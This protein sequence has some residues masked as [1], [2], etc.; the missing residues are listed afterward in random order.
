MNNDECESTKSDD[1]KKLK[2][3]EDREKNNKLPK[4]LGTI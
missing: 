3:T 1:D 2:Q 4:N